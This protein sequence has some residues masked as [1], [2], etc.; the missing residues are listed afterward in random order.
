METKKIILLA[1]VCLTLFSFV[2]AVPPIPDH[3]SGNVL[4]DN[5]NAPIG[6]EIKVYVSGVLEKTYTVSTEG[7][8]NIY[9]LSGEINDLIEFKILDKSASDP[10]TRQGGENIN[11]NLTTISTVVVAPP[12]S[13]PTSSDGSSGGGGGGGGSSSSSSIITK[14]EI[15]QNETDLENPSSTEINEIK[16]LDEYDEK[17]IGI[18]GA[19]IGFFGSNKGITVIAIILIILGI[20]VVLIKFKRRKWKKN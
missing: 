8:Y 6:T 9:I 13:T 1:F 4:I 19:A 12:A 18:T 20:G 17:T 15:I 16:D 11:L 3:F 2:S 7:K 14:N 10:Q 5:Q